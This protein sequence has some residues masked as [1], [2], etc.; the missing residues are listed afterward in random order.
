[1][2]S[3][4]YSIRATDPLLIPLALPGLCFGIKTPANLLILDSCLRR[5]DPSSL[6]YEGQDL[7][8]AIRFFRRVAET[9]A[10]LKTKP[11]FPPHAER[12]IKA[13]RM[14]PLLPLPK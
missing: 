9:P 11:V 5:N 12:G 2:D 10:E 13:A 8:R 1:M 4:G 6:R 7:R 14:D 3:T